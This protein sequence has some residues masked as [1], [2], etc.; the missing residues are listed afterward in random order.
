MA[1]STNPRT[2]RIDVRVSDAEDALIREAATLSGQTV[3]AFLLEAAEERARAVVDERRHLVMSAQEF[4]RF[5]EAL[6]EPAEAVPEL[7]ELFR[8]PRLG[9]A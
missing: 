1:R 7:V 6:D 5:A 2:R 8:L 4:A 9:T 3:T